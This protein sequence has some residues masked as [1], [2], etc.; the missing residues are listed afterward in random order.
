MTEAV[1]MVIQSQL[2]VLI[3]TPIMRDVMFSQTT[4]TSFSGM[5]ALT[6]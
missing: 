1:Q 4:V 2:R 6:H 5:S 3:R